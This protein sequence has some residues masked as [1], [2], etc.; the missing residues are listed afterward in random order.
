MINFAVRHPKITDFFISLVKQ[1]LDHR[2]KN[3]TRRPDFLQLLIDINQANGNVE[4]L[5]FE[6]IVANTILFFIAGKV[7]FYTQKTLPNQ[8]V[9]LG[10]D[11]SSSTMTFTLLLL[12]QNPEIQAKTRQEIQSVLDKHNG[13]LTYECLNEMTYLRQVIDG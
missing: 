13:Q 8:I 9:C 10:F 2:S 1:T 3:N 5:K 12:A 7:Y 4:V 11:T 6:Q